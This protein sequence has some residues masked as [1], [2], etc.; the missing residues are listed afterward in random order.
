MSSSYAKVTSFLYYK[1]IGDLILKKILLIIKYLLF[2][3]SFT[4]LYSMEHICCIE[5]WTLSIPF[6]NTKNYQLNY[7]HLDMIPKITE[8]TKQ[9]Y[10]VPKE[11]YT[12]IKET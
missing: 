3:S 7:K 8:F 5:I 6:K 11:A 10:M 2:S 1:F 4:Y 9:A 12:C